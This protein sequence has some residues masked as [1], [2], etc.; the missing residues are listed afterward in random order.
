LSD[1]LYAAS[2]NDVKVDFEWCAEYCGSVR[3]PA[4]EGNPAW[5]ISDSWLLVSQ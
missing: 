5:R 3:Q 4:K 1:E 2:W